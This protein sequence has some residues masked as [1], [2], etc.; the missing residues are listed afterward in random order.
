MRSSFGLQ[1]S[2]DGVPDGLI[3]VEGAKAKSSLW[4][5]W[6]LNIGGI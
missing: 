5:E 2:K 4:W 6:Y 1:V 3:S